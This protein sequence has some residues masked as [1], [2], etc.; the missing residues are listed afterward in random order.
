MAWIDSC[1]E[2]FLPILGRMKR[3]R[4]LVD[5]IENGNDIFAVFSA[6]KIN[7]QNNEVRK[8]SIRKLN[9]LIFYL[10]AFGSSSLFWL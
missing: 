2:Q 10:E 3:T 1:H 8:L 9:A 6:M 4:K 5:Q 7:E